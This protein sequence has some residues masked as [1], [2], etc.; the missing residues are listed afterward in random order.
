[1]FNYI[2]KRL[3]AA[4][5]NATT[6]AAEDDLVLHLNRAERER[7]RLHQRVLALEQERIQMEQDLS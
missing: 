5:N 4:R 1:M 3:S 2:I 7:A 6:A